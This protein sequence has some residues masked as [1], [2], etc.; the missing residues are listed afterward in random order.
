[1][2]C[3]D[4]YAQYQSHIRVLGKSL[5]LQPLIGNHAPQR[6]Y[7]AHSRNLCSTEDTLHANSIPFRHHIGSIALLALLCPWT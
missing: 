3:K 6:E 7:V 1:M 2:E 5:M 4:N